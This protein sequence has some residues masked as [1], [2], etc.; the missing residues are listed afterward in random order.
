MHSNLKPRINS[1]LSKLIRSLHYFL[2]RDSLFVAS[3]NCATS[4]FAGFV[5]FSIVGFMAHELGV[6]VEEVADG[7]K[8]EFCVLFRIQI[9]NGHRKYSRWGTPIFEGCYVRLLRPPFSLFLTQRPLKIVLTQRPHVFRVSDYKFVTQNPHVTCKQL[10]TYAVIGYNTNCMIYGHAQP[11]IH[12]TVPYVNQTPPGLDNRG[13]P[14][15]Q[16]YQ[17]WSSLFRYCFPGEGC[18]ISCSLDRESIYGYT[19][20]IFWNKISITSNISYATL[21]SVIAEVYCVY[22]V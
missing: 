3:A 13:P 7:G 1:F 17:R 12:I 9:H 2:H 16:R 6:P 8:L 21:G 22:Y 14:T 20:M 4:F 15:M 5:I 18:I 10:F 19:F 11:P